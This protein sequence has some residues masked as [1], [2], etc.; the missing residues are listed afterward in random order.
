MASE[1]LGGI[2]AVESILQRAPASVQ[3][4]VL[5]QSRNE[6]RLQ[7]ILKIAAREGIAAERLDA[8]EL[9]RQFP[10]IRHQGVVAICRPVEP[11]SETQMQQ[12][13]A[14]LDRPGFVLVLDGVTDPHNLGALLRSADA[15]GVDAVISPKDNSAS[16]TPVVRKVASGAADTVPFCPVTNLARTLAELKDLGYWIY[17][18]A[19]EAS[20]PYTQPDYRGPVA[21]VMGAEGSGLRRLTRQH[22]D[23]LIGIPMA[24]A[25]SSLNVSVAAGVCLF[26]VVRQRNRAV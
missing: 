21:L 3:K 24:G 7:S 2:H 1:S 16:I 11:I 20:E 12:L 6:K 23:V 22:C 19:D 14:A 17:G 5:A 25:V 15:A 4:L 26:E 13:L 8:R 9:D 10:Q 18:A